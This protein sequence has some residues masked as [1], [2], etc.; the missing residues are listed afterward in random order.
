MDAEPPIA[1]FLM[2]MLVGGGPVNAVVRRTNGYSMDYASIHSRLKPTNGTTWRAVI[3]DDRFRLMDCPI[4]I[5]IHTRSVPDESL[6]PEIST[7]ESQLADTIL[8]GLDTCIAESER[9]LEND[10]TIEYIRINGGAKI[11]NPHIWISRDIVTQ[12]GANRWAMVLGVD[13]NPDFGWHIEFDGLTA[14]EIWAG[15]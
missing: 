4:A 2:S 13:A 8:N 14:L 10:P 5:E 9:L 3:E 15:D 1:S 6:I 7:V 11:V 12:D